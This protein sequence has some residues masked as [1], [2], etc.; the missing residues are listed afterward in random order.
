V[1]VSARRRTVAALAVCLILVLGGLGAAASPAQAQT[2]GVTL[3]AST[4][5]VTFGGKVVLT[6]TVDPVAEG[7]GVA[8]V[9]ADG[10]TV[11]SGTTGSAGRFKT[12]LIPRAD[13]TLHASSEG[14]DSAPV[15]V[16]VRPILTLGTG[17]A[18][19]YGDLAI[20]GRFRPA[21]P[22]LDVRI[23][24][25]RS[26]EVVATK[27]APMGE[28]GRFATSVRLAETGTYR[29]KAF[30][31][32]DDLLPAA[33]QAVVAV[34]PAPDL[35]IGS[36]GP[37]VEVLERRLVELHYHLRGV[38]EVFDFRTAD[39]V[40]AFRKVQRMPRVQTVTSAV[41]RALARPRMFVPHDRGDGF[42]IEVDQTRQ[43]L[44]TVRDGQVEAIFH[45]STGKA[46]TPTRD[47]TFQVYSK[48][49]GFSPKRLYYP[50]FFDGERA[51]HGWT[52]VPTYPASHGC[53]RVPYWIAIWIYEQAD[54]GTPVIVY[55]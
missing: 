10:R 33:A 44:A 18:L 42:H 6:A 40:M 11:A 15:T 45:V 31:D 55:H 27:K 35:A 52:E 16:S 25:L 8:I 49:A 28:G 37:A 2:T 34:H 3:V 36:R 12:T 13:L 21:R 1:R 54:Y 19:L 48:L 32:A 26:G 38:D 9:D 22:G 23:Q 50:S 51:I 17:T 30:L 39:A 47:G 5:V 43:V 4:G 14:V 24:L 29:V 20:S 53:V 7:V 41:W 46:S